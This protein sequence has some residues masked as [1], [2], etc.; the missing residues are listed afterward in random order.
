MQLE[1]KAALCW[2]EYDHKPI[3]ILHIMVSVTVK[4]LDNFCTL[5]PPSLANQRLLLLLHHGSFVFCWIVHNTHVLSPCHNDVDKWIFLYDSCVLVLYHCLL[6]LSGTHNMSHIVH[7]AQYIE[8]GFWNKTL[9]MW[10]T[11]V[12]LNIIFLF[13]AGLFALAG[14]YQMAVWA[15]GKHRAYKKDFKNYPARKAILPFLL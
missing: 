15:L 13:L 5:G 10:E 7:V 2:N 14:F 6:P 4:S 12:Y 9:W 8:Q 11:S 3:F 1:T